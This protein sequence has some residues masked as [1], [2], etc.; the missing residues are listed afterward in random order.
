MALSFRRR[1]SPLLGIAVLL[2]SAVA[3][4]G[5]S[6]SLPSPACAATYHADGRGGGS[7]ATLGEPEVAALDVQN[8]EELH[9]A[10]RA[11]VHDLLIRLAPGEY[12]LSPSPYTDPTCGNC[13]NLA[14]PSQT[15]VG[16]HIRG[17][18]IALRGPDDRSAIIHTGAG[19][20]LY[21]EEA[22]D[23]VIEGL[24]ITGGTRSEDGN[25]TD[26][27]VVVKNSS[28][29]IRNN[30]IHENLGAPEVVRKTVSGIIGIVGREGAD[31]RIIANDITRNSWDG[32]A[33]YRG[34]RAVIENN[35]VDGIDAATGANIGGGRGVGIGVTW[36]ARADIRGNLVKRYWKGIGLF[37]NAH[38][39]VEH[40]IVEEITTWGISLWDAGGGEPRGIIRSN[41]VYRTGACGIAIT[42][43]RTG[44]DVGELTANAI[45]RAAQDPRYDPPDRYC[46]QC[47]LAL[48]RVPEHFRIE[49]NLFFDNRHADEGLPDLD[50]SEEL[51]RQ[52]VSPLTETLAGYESLRTAAFLAEFAPTP[53]GAG[54]PPPDDQP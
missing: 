46:L 40:N 36:D 23:V 10:L 35:V 21:L 53:A 43:R 39:T 27:A 26:G 12:R 11:P 34:A 44:D 48:H 41:A 33:L 31:M 30:L 25:A 19:Y 5:V 47:A 37:V 16:L 22:R 7:G 52:R 17:R 15:T 18:N 29:L 3:V 9:H 28:V 54:D 45:V 4:A 42:S 14:T 38:G 8:A 24:T 32:I 13:R 2:L 49:E 50:I 20:G 51:F 1:S 6:P